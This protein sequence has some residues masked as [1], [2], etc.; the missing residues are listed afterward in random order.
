MVAKAAERGGSGI[1]RA[2]ST[3]VLISSRFGG[4]K[5]LRMIVYPKLVMKV[6]IHAA[7]IPGDERGMII[8]LNVSILLAPR[9]LLASIRKSFI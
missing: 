9:S 5:K 2:F 1:P 7:T 4:P 6:K 8:L 3:T